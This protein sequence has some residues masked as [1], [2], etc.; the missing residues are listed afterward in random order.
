M[1]FLESND[2]Y[3]VDIC[4]QHCLEAEASDAAA[5]LLE[6]RGDVHGALKLHLDAVRSADKKLIQALKHNIDDM[7]RMAKPRLPEEELKAARNALHGVL[8]MC[9]RFSQDHA[10]LAMMAR[11]TSELDGSM[12]KNNNAMTEKDIVA[13]SSVAAANSISSVWIEVLEHYVDVLHRLF[14]E[15]EEEGGSEFVEGNFTDEMEVNEAERCLVLW[16]RTVL[17]ET[18]MEF[19]HHV[20]REMS[21]HVASQTVVV[22]LLDRYSDVKFGRF[23]GILL[24]LLQSCSFQYTI[25]DCVGRSSRLDALSLLRRGYRK[26]MEPTHVAVAPSNTDHSNIWDTR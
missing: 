20:I 14:R 8:S 3:D 12:Q 16:G 19:V 2:A 25:S 15:G 7:H 10:P 17:Q 23:R 6:R 13:K 11:T 9:A 4:L 26:C 5:F 18:F 21:E 22:S 24:D 1:K